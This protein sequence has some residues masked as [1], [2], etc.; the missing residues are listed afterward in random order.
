MRGERGLQRELSTYI[1]RRCGW[2]IV[3]YVGCDC[4]PWA[5]S[6]DGIVHWF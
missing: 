5:A 1:Q 3:G 2:S 4:A 6:G